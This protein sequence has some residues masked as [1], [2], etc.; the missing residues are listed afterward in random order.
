MAATT[1]ELHFQTGLCIAFL[2]CDA[3]GIFAAA[4]P[5]NRKPSSTSL[6][7]K[8][9]TITAFNSNSNTKLEFEVP[10]KLPG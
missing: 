6:N 9:N 4:Q 2:T 1:L 3:D 8:L 7:S 5:S 10:I